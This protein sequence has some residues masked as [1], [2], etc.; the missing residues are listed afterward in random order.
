GRTPAAASM[1]AGFVSL[2]SFPTTLGRSSCDDTCVLSG[3]LR[4]LRPGG[5]VD[6]MAELLVFALHGG[7]ACPPSG[8][9]RGGIRH[10]GFHEKY[11][12]N[13]TACSFDI[14]HQYGIMMTMVRG[15]EI[16]PQPAGVEGA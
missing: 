2:M 10:P 6:Q 4:S 8:A 15:E 13:G 7:P 16:F 11:P 3:A 9:W 12:V 1:I 5:D 14:G